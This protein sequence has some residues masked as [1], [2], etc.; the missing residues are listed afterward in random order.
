[1]QQSLAPELIVFPYYYRA[2]QLPIGYPL[3]RSSPLKFYCVCNARGSSS[4]RAASA[5]STLCFARNMPPA[6]ETWGLTETSPVATANPIGAE[7]NGSIG[8]PIPS[9]DISRP[10]SRFAHGSRPAPILA[11]CRGKC[12]EQLIEIARPS[13][14]RRSHVGDLSTLTSRILPEAI[15]RVLFR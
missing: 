1:M 5:K 3:V 9:T 7:F 8:L 4:D 14:N 12:V 11:S 10:T 2:Y 13:Q 6:K 15:E